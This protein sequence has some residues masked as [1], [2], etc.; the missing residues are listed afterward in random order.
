MHLL[1]QALQVES[2]S[3]EHP[4]RDHVSRRQPHAAAAPPIP[5]GLPIPAGDRHLLIH[6]HVLDPR[7]LPGTASERFQCLRGRVGL[8][9]RLHRLVCDRSGHD[10]ARRYIISFT[11]CAEDAA[12]VYALADAALG[13]EAPELDVIPLFETFEDLHNAPDVL[14]AMLE[15]PQYQQRLEQTGRRVE[16]MRRVKLRALVSS[17]HR[18][19]SWLF[20]SYEG[21]ATGTTIHR[22]SGLTCGAPMRFMSQMSSCV[23]IF[24][25][26]AMALVAPIPAINN[27]ARAAPR[28]GILLMLFMAHTVSQSS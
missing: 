21:S 7:V 4:L 24:F 23:G 28:L 26:A 27:T 22:P 18:S 3:G 9:N 13:S 8:G 16:V 20:S 11:T 6:L 15:I 19:L 14:D 2:I 25:P 17:S 12:N 1:G 10:A 5:A